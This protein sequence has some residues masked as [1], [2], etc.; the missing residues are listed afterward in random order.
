MQCDDHDEDNGDAP[1]VCT[2]AK[3]EKKEQSSYDE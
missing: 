2:G 1:G 3:R